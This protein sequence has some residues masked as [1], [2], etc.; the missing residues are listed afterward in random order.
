MIELKK[1]AW[2][3]EAE[4][5]LAVA[6]GEKLFDV[7]EQVISGRCELWSVG[8][9]GYVVTRFEINHEYKA[10]VLIAG[11]GWAEDGAGY[12]A[13][14]KAFCNVA[15]NIGADRVETETHRPAIGRM[16]KSIGF[17]EVQRKYELD[18]T[19]VKYGQ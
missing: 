19:A 3:D 7:A 2:S 4:K 6:L 18:L 14:V 17:K 10:L 16:I 13:S 15:A 9:H 12:L 8:G 5:G 11:Q 1:L